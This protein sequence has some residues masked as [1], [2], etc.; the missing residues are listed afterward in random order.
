MQLPRVGTAG[1]TRREPQL[2]RI[3]LPDRLADSPKCTAPGREAQFE[4]HRPPSKAYHPVEFRG[5][6][7]SEEP[8]LM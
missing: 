6:P 1:P 3:D 8:E 4:S 7:G 2:A 5:M